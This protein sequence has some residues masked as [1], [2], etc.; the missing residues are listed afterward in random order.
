MVKDGVNLFKDRLKT[1]FYVNLE[2]TNKYF[3]WF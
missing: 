1:A 2:K 3:R